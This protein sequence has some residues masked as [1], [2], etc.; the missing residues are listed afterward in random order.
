MPNQ[1]SEVRRARRSSHIDTDSSRANVVS[2]SD[3]RGRIELSKLAEIRES[4]LSLG[5]DLSDLEIRVF[6]DVGLNELELL[7]L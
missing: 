1:K 4:I 2:L 6:D 7:N 5:P 3:W